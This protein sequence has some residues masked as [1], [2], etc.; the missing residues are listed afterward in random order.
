[1]RTSLVVQWLRLQA[2]NSGG[3]G[4]DPWLENKIPHATTKDP[5]GCS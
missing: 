5:M 3:P 1:M 4:L 2:P